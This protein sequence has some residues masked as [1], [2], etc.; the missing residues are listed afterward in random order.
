[1][2]LTE[3]SVSLTRNL[4]L[5]LPF[6]RRRTRRMSKV[7]CFAAVLFCHPDSKL[8][9]GRL[10]HQNVHQSL[11]PGSRTEIDSDFAYTLTLILLK[12]VRNLPSTFDPSR[13]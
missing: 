10:A 2:V 3:L 1:M 7:L 12:K 11:G 6:I 5:M 13:L 4:L 8:P 9:N